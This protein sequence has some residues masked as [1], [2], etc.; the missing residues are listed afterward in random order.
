MMRA[1]FVQ[2]QRAVVQQ[3]ATVACL[4][5]QFNWNRVTDLGEASYAVDF[6]DFKLVPATV[7]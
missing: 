4:G 3:A 5:S 2:D 6:A 7:K 1:W